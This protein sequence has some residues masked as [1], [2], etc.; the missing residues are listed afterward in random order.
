MRKGSSLTLV[1][2]LLLFIA[3][4]VSAFYFYNSPLF[5]KNSPK[6]TISEQIN[7]NM[8]EPI[9]VQIS[10][11][12]HLNS[13]KAYLSDGTNQ[14]KLSE[15]IFETPVNH[16]ELLIEFPKIGLSTE[17]KEFTLS[18]V[19]NDKSYWNF[20]SG[21]TS[22]KNVTI[23]VDKKKPDVFPVLSSYGITRG[24]A[25]LV[26]FKAEDENLKQL[27]IETNFGKKFYPMPFY[28]TGYFI[29]LVAWP[30]T[31]KRF[32]AKI[33]AADAAG[34]RAKS[35]IN[36][37]LK[38]KE[39]RVSHITVKDN[40]LNGK[41]AD[42]AEDRPKLT[43]N[44]TPIEKFKF[45]N[46]T[47]RQENTQVIKNITRKVEGDMIENFAITPFYP[48]KN[49]MSVASFGDHRFYKYMDQVI[50]ESYHLGLDLASIKM[51][52]IQTTNRGIVMHTDYTGIYGNSVIMYHGLGFY[53]L[54]SHCSNI[55]VK[56]GEV[57]EEKGV[58]AQSGATGLALGDHLHF[59][60][61]VQGIETRPEEWMDKQWIKTNITNI[62]E[63]AK[64]MIDR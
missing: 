52:D 19:A 7:W 10:D 39:Y 18:L 41:I 59:S 46:E 3:I 27:Y 51:A 44:L 20:F 26:V 17:Q 15:Q 43:A 58:I 6:I 22:L 28:K 48:L 53:T 37:F 23:T 62:I 36:F 25:A 21:N 11:D 50:S 12:T 35:K 63:N 49:G 33:I 54:Y 13:V 29:S 38:A 9:K 64:R 5:E 4:I 60:T 32:S 34:N 56:K 30:V 16:T 14:V 57:V 45:I 8:K 31:Q 24:G 2:I 40:F 61:F 1:F 47:Y 42:L 55:F